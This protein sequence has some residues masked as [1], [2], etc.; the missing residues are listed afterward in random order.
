MSGLSKVRE[1]VAHRTTVMVGYSGV[2]KSTLVNALVPD[3]GRTTGVVNAVTG[4]G[5]HT[6][7]SVV[8]LEL[9]STGW[10][11]DTPGVRSFG[12][13]HVT[14]DTILGPFADIAQAATMCPRGCPHTPERDE[15]TLPE[16]ATTEE[17]R[18]RLA[19]VQR[20][21]AGVAAGSGP[22]G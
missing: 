13:A 6:S 10:I 21:L 17:R 9:P 3:A 1:R 11:I 7:T 14:P 15:C 19:S 5:R 22:R 4:R 16:W 12:L 20:L 18:T 8:A 2:G